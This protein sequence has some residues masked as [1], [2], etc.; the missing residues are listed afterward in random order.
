MTEG[1]IL[2]EGSPDRDIIWSASSGSKVVILPQ[3][4]LSVCLHMTKLSLNS[5]LTKERV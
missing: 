3:S 1:R 5:T 4:T 2:L